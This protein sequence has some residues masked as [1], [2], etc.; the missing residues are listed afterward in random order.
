M[1]IPEDENPYESSGVETPTANVE[2]TPDQETTLAERGLMIVIAI[3][4]AIPV[5]FTTCIGGGFALVAVFPYPGRYGPPEQTFI[6]LSFVCFL[7]ALWA[8]FVAAR[9]AKRRKR[10]NV[11]SG[12]DQ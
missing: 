1:A 8:G 4:V 5:F 7:V 9:W 3:V 12:G 2:M 6:I 11:S 10:G